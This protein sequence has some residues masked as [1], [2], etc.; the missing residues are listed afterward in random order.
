M[1]NF[2]W[3]APVG[4]TAEL[5]ACIPGLKPDT[6]RKWQQRD[7]LTRRGDLGPGHRKVWHAEDV[8]EAAI[9]F[10]CSAF[11][12]LQDE[13]LLAR[14]LAQTGM[15]VRMYPKPGAVLD[16]LLVFYR[17]AASGRICYRDFKESDGAAIDLAFDSPEAPDVFLMF[18]VDR[19]I[20][21]LAERI[22]AIAPGAVR[23]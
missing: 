16:R 10:E 21:R 1:R 14:S 19:F 6:F 4:G 3:A 13:P 20:D 11:P 12:M 18:R 22:A 5:L 8:L 2:N 23:S 17:E 15:V 9:A 7:R